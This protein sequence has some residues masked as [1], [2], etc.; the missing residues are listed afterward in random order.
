M[1]EAIAMNETKKQHVV[2]Q[3][4]LQNFNSTPGK[5]YVFKKNS[6]CS[7]M[8]NPYNGNIKNCAQINKIGNPPA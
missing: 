8:P 1:M 6:V 2:P 5:T 7:S 3:W 4:Y